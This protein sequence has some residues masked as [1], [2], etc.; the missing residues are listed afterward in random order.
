MRCATR[1]NMKLAHCGA[2][3][4]IMCESCRCVQ[5]VGFDVLRGIAIRGNFGSGS[6]YQFDDCVDFFFLIVTFV[7]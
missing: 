7:E 4:D 6:F 1:F 5:F 2:L 3:I